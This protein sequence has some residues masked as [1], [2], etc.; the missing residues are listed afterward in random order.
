MALELPVPTYIYYTYMEEILYLL[1]WLLLTKTNWDDRRV[2]A[3]WNSALKMCK[4]PT[5]YDPTQTQGI[6]V[7]LIQNHA[8]HEIFW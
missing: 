7:S 5:M 8:T 1:G 2:A 4:K 6:E 3:N